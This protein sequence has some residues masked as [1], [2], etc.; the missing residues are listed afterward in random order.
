MTGPVQ[1]RALADP[2]SDALVVFTGDTEIAWV[3]RWLR[4][5]FRHCFVLVRRGGRWI[6]FDPL[7]H[8]IDLDVPDVPEGFDMGGWL[9]AQ[10][11]TVVRARVD[12]APAPPALFAPFSCVEAVKRVLGLR[13]PWVVTPWR[14]YRHLTARPRSPAS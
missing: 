7:A 12:R 9:R 3:R 8:R 6:S 13:A 11:F 14:L 4:A 10:G 1:P 2:P 5:G